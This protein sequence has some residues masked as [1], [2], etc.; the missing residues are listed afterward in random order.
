MCRNTGQCDNALERLAVTKMSRHRA[1]LEILLV[2]VLVAVSGMAV[3]VLAEA[4]DGRMPL[5]MLLVLQ[6]AVILVGLTML[7]AHAGQRWGDVGL[8]AIQ[9][10]DLWRALLLFAACIGANLLLML[11][12]YVVVPDYVREHVYRLQDIA[13]RL[14]DGLPITAIAA[15]MFFVGVYEELTARGFLLARF[16]T[17]LHGL[18]APVLLSSMLFGLGHVYQGWLGVAQTVVIGSV[19][20]IYTVRWATLWPAILAHALLNTLSIAVLA[21]LNS[22]QGVLIYSSL[23]EA[24]SLNSRLLTVVVSSPHT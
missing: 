18:W 21:E 12:V 5:S 3:A 24:S 8:R 9:A 23:S 1:W 4:S 20:A 22:S 19:F 6:G 10:R 16:L 15:T 11:F 13:S 2:L 7:L 17:A 14:A